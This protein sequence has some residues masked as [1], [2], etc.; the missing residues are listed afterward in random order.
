MLAQLPHL[1]ESSTLGSELQFVHKDT[2][3][4]LVDPIWNT[5]GDNNCFNVIVRQCFVEAEHKGQLGSEAKAIRVP[6]RTT[7][8]IL[9]QAFSYYMEARNQ[10]SVLW[11]RL[12]GGAVNDYKWS[13]CPAQLS[14]YSMECS[15][16]VTHSEPCWPRDASNSG[17][18]CLRHAAL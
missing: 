13:T 15:A 3:K 17:L 12:L 8:R 1:G 14:A 5:L 11:A 2:R 16:D 10:E 4:V 6:S 18:R 9:P 7:D